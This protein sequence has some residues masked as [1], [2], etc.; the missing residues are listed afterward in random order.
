MVPPSGVIF[1]ASMVDFLTNPVDIYFVSMLMQ[2]TAPVACLIIENTTTTTSQQVESNLLAE[3]HPPTPRDLIAGLDRVESMLSN[4]IK[5][6]E[7]VKRSHRTTSPPP[8]MPLGL[9]T[10]ARAVSDYMNNAN[11]AANFAR[12][13]RQ[14][15]AGNAGQNATARSPIVRATRVL[16]GS[17]N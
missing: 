10:A 16:R 8:C 12:N 7:S 14:I 5:V 17:Q 4:T 15:V 3:T 1:P 9:R 2:S 11:N 13:Q 6:C